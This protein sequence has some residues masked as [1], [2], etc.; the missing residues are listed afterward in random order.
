MLQPDL[1]R[2]RIGSSLMVL[3][4][5]AA[6]V[7]AAADEPS[8]PSAPQ[9]P[10]STATADVL[11]V[12]RSVGQRLANFTLTDAVTGRP[13]ML[14]GY[15]G[16]TGMVLVFMGTTCPVGDVYMPRLAEISRDYR[17][18]GF[19]VLG[20]NSNAHETNAEIAAH[21][22]KFNL[23]FPVLKDRDN[24]IADAALIER[25]PEVL[26]L[27]GMARICYRG[28]IDDQ[29]GVGA[30]K[31]AAE[32]H[33]L[34]DALDS[35]AAKQPVK[36]KA[37]AAVGCLIEK[38]KTQAVA[39]T[40]PP[41]VR[42]PA[43]A[44]A[45]AHDADAIKAADIGQVTYS[46]AAAAII[47]NR[48]ESCH[49][50]GQ[51]AP[52]SLLSYDDARKHSAMIREVVDNR[53][54]PPWHADPKYGHF[55][56]DRSLTAKERATLLAWIDQGAPLGE[57]KNIPAARTYP[58][59]WSIGTPDLVLEIPETYT[60]PK[61]GVVAYVRFRVPTNFKEDRWVQAAEAVPGDRSVVH[62]IVVY[63]DTHQKER[64]EG[65]GGRHFCGYAPGDMPS[66]FPEGTAKR[67]PAGS[68]LIFELHYTPI[69]EVRQDRSKLGLIFAKKPPTREAFT[70]AVFESDFMIPPNKDDVAVASS[71]TLSQDLRLLSFMPHMHLRGKDFRYTITRPDQA[72]EVALS[73]PAYDFGWQSYYT[74]AEPLTLP[75]GTRIDC[76]AHFDNTSNNLNNPDPNKL[77]RWG[78]QTFEE[79]MI[80][81]IDVDV[82]VGTAVSRAPGRQPSVGR[83][84]FQA[85]SGR[86]PRAAAP[87]QAKP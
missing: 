32:R 77:V 85:L 87:R 46:S 55:A 50:P 38:V 40:S 41:R 18:K 82:P 26:V 28:A 6:G 86:G 74:L 66:V 39:K 14:Y 34:R 79:M 12:D 70:M 7:R 84:V 48:C 53:R 33:Y 67:I 52:F 58:Q 10:S 45:A 37:T 24:L 4:A 16:K 30:R 61:Q 80:G 9:P 11:P 17:A 25:T 59:G 21:A 5:L 36:V 68:D 20:V 54:M 73:V 43:P 19:V 35:L 60:V 56:N 78:E 23:D 72:P 65:L 71:T 51:V 8:K 13:Y 63:L 47:Q 44:I 3:A 27:D 69:G 76:L 15:A 49:R 42:P 64:A 81:Y 29:Y 75:K 83:Q 1:L 22:R 62:H 57:P 31:P 2:N